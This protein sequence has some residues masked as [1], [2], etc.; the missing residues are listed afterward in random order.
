MSKRKVLDLAG[1]REAYEQY[2]SLDGQTREDLGKKL[3][4]QTF[5]E[6]W[7]VIQGYM[8]VKELQGE[9]RSIANEATQKI[10]SILL[11]ASG[12]GR[13]RQK[14]DPE[15][16]RLVWDEREGFHVP[17]DGPSTLRRDNDRRPNW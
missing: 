3:A 11:Q 10:R 14:D 9:A 13:R 8:K 6:I 12:K 17:D 16:P 4:Y 15:E 5:A 2:E 1:L 7:E